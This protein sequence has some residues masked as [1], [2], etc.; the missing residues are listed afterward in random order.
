MP[1]LVFA[2]LV[3]GDD[4][5]MVQVGRRFGFGAETGDLILVREITGAHE[6]EGNEAVETDLA[7]AIDDAHAAPADFLQQFVVADVAN[8]F[9]RPSGDFGFL[10]MRWAFQSHC[11]TAISHGQADAQQ[12]RRA[13]AAGRAK[14]HGYATVWACAQVGHGSWIK[15][16]LSYKRICGGKSLGT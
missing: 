12:A 10:P 15:L 16:S 14:R 3:N 1:A 5:R 4:I 6:L 11:Q 13:M 2:D 9:R 8:A 7:G